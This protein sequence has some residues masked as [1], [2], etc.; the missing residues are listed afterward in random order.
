M[1]SGRFAAHASI[2]ALALALTACGGGGGGGPG[3]TPNPPAPTPTPV[4]VYTPM[5][6]PLTSNT[7][8]ET[9]GYDENL[10]GRPWATGVKI[11]YLVGSDTIR[12]EV[13]DGRQFDFDNPNPEFHPFE[14]LVSFLGRPPT[15][16]GMLQLAVAVAPVDEVPLTYL[17]MGRFVL[18]NGTSADTVST[19]FVFGSHTRDMPK[20]GTATYSTIV[21]GDGRDR[22]SMLSPMYLFN[23]E[24]DAAFTAN[25]AT[26]TVSTMLHLIGVR[27]TGGGPATDFGTFSGSGAISQQAFQG[28]FEDVD[29]GGFWGSFFGP[30]GAEMGYGYMIVDGTFSSQGVVVG[31]KN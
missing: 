4:V 1:S 20:T 16:S 10:G 13:Q 28:S 27:A 18:I 29:R 21:S 9:V 7:T 23:V 8:Y 30:G 3:S 31:R 15:G 14:A 17:R 25:F 19:Q 22:S 2:A 5:T 26:G 11:G 24:S 12:L 6:A